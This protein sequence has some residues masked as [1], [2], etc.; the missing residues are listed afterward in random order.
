MINFISISSF[1]RVV[2]FSEIFFLH[3]T[4][5]FWSEIDKRISLASSQDHLFLLYLIIQ[6]EKVMG[7]HHRRLPSLT[8][9]SNLRTVVRI[10]TS[11]HREDHRSLVT[12]AT[13]YLT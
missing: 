4:S 6:K 1:I 12:P 11:H 2:T 10:R 13:T 5:C 9:I 7:S 8:F 3:N